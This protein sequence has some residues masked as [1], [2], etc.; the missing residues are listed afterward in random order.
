MDGTLRVG[1]VVDDVITTVTE[2]PLGTNKATHV[3][4]VGSR[5]VVTGGDAV[6]AAPFTNPC[7]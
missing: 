5:I 2:L 1:C 7:H 4:V 3:Q 6:R